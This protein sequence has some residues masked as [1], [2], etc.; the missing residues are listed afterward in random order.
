MR[1]IYKQNT[2][3]NKNKA[4]VGDGA[5]PVFSNNDF[6]DTFICCPRVVILISIDKQNEICILLDRA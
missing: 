5:V 3:T 2:L 4:D 1:T 6:G